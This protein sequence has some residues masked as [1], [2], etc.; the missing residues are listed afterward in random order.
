MQHNKKWLVLLCAVI[1]VIGMIT[2]PAIADAGNFSGNSSYGGS[3]SSGS[4]S[5]GGS[6]SSYSSYDDDY[7]SSG[8][9]SGSGGGSIVAAVVFVAIIFILSR[10][11]KKGSQS[12]ANQ[13]I[14]GVG[15]PTELGLNN[16]KERDP[17]FSEEAI[18]EKVANLYVQMQNA[19][20]NKKFESM[21]PHMTDMLYSQFD[22]QL[23]ELVKAQYTNYIDRIAV[24]S[25]NI[26]GCS[27]DEVNETLTVIIETRIVDYT[28][29]DKTGDLISGDRSMEKFM[30]YEWQLIR[31]K[32]MQTPPPAGEG[33]QGTVAINCPNCG[34]PLNI[35]QSAQCP[36]CGTLVTAKDYDWTISSIKGLAQRNGN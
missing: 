10:L 31:S 17:N 3:S 27:E 8:S 32:G 12:A 7:S 15:R 35:N 14:G 25:V 13:G 21:R 2:V 9:G 6:S 33:S 34:A 4:S 28:L 5:W 19:W 18:E 36:Y 24:L 1:L 22:R 23:D 16:L 29:N 26:R 30:T 20:Q 11:K